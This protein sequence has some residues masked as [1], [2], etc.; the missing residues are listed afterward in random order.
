[1]PDL[2]LLASLD[3]LIE[4]TNVTRAA[5]RLG[6]SQPA[7][8]AQLARLRDLFG[9]PLLVPSETGRGMVPTARA[10]ALRD[11]LHTALKD[12]KTIMRRPPDFDPRCDTRDF[13][14]SSSDLATTIL[15][16]PLVERIREVA[17]SGIRLSF[18]NLP[19]NDSGGTA[20]ER[21][22]VDL[23][24]GAGQHL[25]ASMKVFKLFD[26]RYVAIRRKDQPHGTGTLDLAGYCEVDHLVVSPINGDFCGSVDEQLKIL[27]RRRHVVLSVPQFILAP[28]I[29]ERTDLVATIPERFAR[30]F[31]DRVDVSELPFRTPD[32]SLF[33]AWHPRSHEDPAHIWLRNWLA[34]LA[35]TSARGIAT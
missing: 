32:F 1:M 19:P 7:L 2:N 4:E 22:D 29:V 23:V 20:L 25:P 33:A 3:V 15:G 14:I 5:M 28:M 24:I 26:E 31:A 8:S 35:Q 10:L 13:A 17:G 11:P 16:F 6:L 9:D 27:G 21:G 34:E 18:R 30:R 12:L